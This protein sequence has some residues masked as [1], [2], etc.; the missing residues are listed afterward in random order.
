MIEI[1]ARG[2]RRPARRRA[3]PATSSWRGGPVCSST[4]STRV[5]ASTPTAA[6]RMFVATQGDLAFRDEYLRAGRDH[7]DPVPDARE[8]RADLRPARPVVRR[9]G[10]A[11]AAA[12]SRVCIRPS[13]ARPPA[14]SARSAS[15]RKPRPR[16][17]RSRPRPTVTSPAALNATPRC[18]ARTRE[19]TRTPDDSENGDRPRDFGPGPRQTGRRMN[20]RLPM[21]PFGTVLFPYAVLPLHVFEPRYRA[22]TEHCLAGR[23]LLRRRAHRARQ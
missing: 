9:V 21:F 2:R 16:S 8:P 17:T 13:A 7:G 22:L 18:S 5:R 15:S 3:C 20:R 23:R 4:R 6:G 10:G 12:R 19:L 11:A 1:G 14:C